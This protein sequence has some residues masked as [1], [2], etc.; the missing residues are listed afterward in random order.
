MSENREAFMD[1][2]EIRRNNAAALM[3]ENA[4]DELSFALC[5]GKDEVQIAALM[6]P[7]SKKVIPDALARLMEQTFSKPKLWLDLIEDG[8][9]AQGPSFDLFG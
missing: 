9:Q 7:N 2:A 5:L 3:L 6:S 1:L 4:L 8:S